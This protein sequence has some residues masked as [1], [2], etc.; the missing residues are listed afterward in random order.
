[1]GARARIGVNPEGLGVHDLP[2]RFWAGGRGGHRG[3]V[4]ALGGRGRVS[5]NT[6]AYFAQKVR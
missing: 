3:V 5:E 1:L 6:I 4:G 2:D